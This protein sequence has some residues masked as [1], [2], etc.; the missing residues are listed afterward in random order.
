[1]AKFRKTKL[2]P[3]YTNGKPTFKKMYRPGAYIIYKQTGDKKTPL[4]VGFSASNVYKTLYRHFQS[5]NDKTQVRTTYNRTGPFKVRIIL[6]GPKT[7]EKLERAL[8]K[9]L[10]PKDNPRKLTSFLTKQD[11]RYIQE[12]NSTSVDF[13]LTNETEAPF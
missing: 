3:A 12:L 11:I 6:A 8:L 2:A 7:A 5:W 13:S 10:K 1:M 4:Y 9:R